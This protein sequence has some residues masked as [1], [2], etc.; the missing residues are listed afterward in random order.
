MGI[1]SAVYNFLWGDLFTI[2]IGGGI[3][4][5][6]LVALVMLF[7]GGV[8]AYTFVWDLGDIGIGLMTI[9]NLVAVIPMSGK[10]LA[11]PR[12]YEARKEELR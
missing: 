7:I 10:A 8:A 6:L 4:I 3:G 11:A 5:S 1:I 9:F 2:P 12:D